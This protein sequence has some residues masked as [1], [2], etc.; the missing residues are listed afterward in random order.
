MDEN[1]ITNPNEPLNISPASAAAAPKK[2]GHVFMVWRVLY[3]LLIFVGIQIAVGI[4]MTVFYF[5]TRILPVINQASDPLAMSQQLT[6]WAISQTLP[7]ALAC[8]LLVL[9]VYAFMYFR[10]MKGQKRPAISA[11]KITDYVLVAALAVFADFGITYF[12][13]G[14]NIVQYFPDY[15]A[16][17]KGLGSSPVI[18]QVIAVG[19]VAPVAEE[20][21]MRGVVL[22]RLLG[23]MRVFPALLIQAALFGILHM[24]LLQGVYA[25]VLGLLL[26]YVYIKYGSL[27]MT[28]VFHITLNTLSVLLPESFAVEVNPLLII[29]P[30]VLL[31][32]GTLWLIRRRGGSAMFISNREAQKAPHEE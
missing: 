19:I 12:I 10:Q 22:N 18:L 24:N 21:L 5:V 13:S 20:F 9:P 23:Y 6:E 4:A 7:L 25:G 2:H 3:P 16:I 17:M 15:Q 32:A 27:L 31:A 29:V 26:G 1:P 14:F 28:I 11:F 30:A 8:D